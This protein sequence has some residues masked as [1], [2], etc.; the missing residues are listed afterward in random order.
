MLDQR[1]LLR[2]GRH[3]MFLVNPRDRFIGRALAEYGEFSEWEAAALAEVV[4]PGAVVVEAGAN[5]GALTVPIA[6]RIGAAGWLF[7]FEP[8]R[9]A[10]QLLCANAALNELA[11]V[12]AFWAAVGKERGTIKVPVLDPDL[13]CNV[14]GLSL[15]DVSAV[16]P[17]SRE[18]VRLMTIDDLQLGRCDLIKADVE[19]MERD[20]LAGAHETIARCRPML[21]LE[22]DR[23][24][25][26]AGLIDDVLALGYRAWW[27]TPPLFNPKNWAKRPDDVWKAESGIDFVSINMLCVPLEHPVV[28]EGLQPVE[29]GRGHEQLAHVG[30]RPKPAEALAPAGAQP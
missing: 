6:R 25:T 19:G 27:H 17:S 26:G 14:G 22:N 1:Y 18:D 21:Y 13:P 12:V 20:V 30:M 29:A 8:Q 3:G 2:Q 9:L 7:A 16:P 10:F 11:N 15:R 24:E 28:I 23:P 4:K 5:I